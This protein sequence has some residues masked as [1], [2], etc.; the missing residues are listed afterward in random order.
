[1]KFEE[2]SIPMLLV[3]IFNFLFFYRRYP[4]LFG[5]V[6]LNKPFLLIFCRNPHLDKCIHS[7]TN[8]LS[9]LIPFLI[10]SSLIYGS[11]TLSEHYILR[12]FE[13]GGNLFYKTNDYI[14][15]NKEIK[16]D[17]KQSSIEH[18]N[19][20]PSHKNFDYIISK[21]DKYLTII[22][23]KKNMFGTID[24]LATLDDLMMTKIIKNIQQNKST[25]LVDSEN[26]S[27][28]SSKG[29]RGSHPLLNNDVY[30]SYA[31]LARKV[32]LSTL[33]Y[34]VN[35]N[36]KLISGNFGWYIYECN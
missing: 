32:R 14:I 28:D 3:F 12:Y 27:V 16:L 36:C 25:I 34:Y 22:Y 19:N 26:F 5:V 15:N 6:R 9:Y 7:I 20:F 13:S 10:A 17:L 4:I 33:S 30:V 23:D 1:M 8:F 21:N 29:I 35:D 24:L 31:N 11:F 2:Y 18:I